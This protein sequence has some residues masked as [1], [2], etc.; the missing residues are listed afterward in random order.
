V[1]A[2]QSRL[3]PCIQKPIVIS[4]L[5]TAGETTTKAAARQYLRNSARNERHVTTI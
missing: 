5:K 4:G 2:H 3:E 1:A